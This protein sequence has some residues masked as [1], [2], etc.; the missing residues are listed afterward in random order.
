MICESPLEAN[1]QF[2][3]SDKEHA[4]KP[5]NAIPMAQRHHRAR[6]PRH[7]LGKGGHDNGQPDLL[8]YA[9]APSRRRKRACDLDRW[10]RNARRDRTPM[11]V[12][13]DLLWHS[14]LD[15]VVRL[16]PYLSRLD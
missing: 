13:P 8:Q 16:D 15:W 10:Q 6:V 4:H 11:A 14:S 7:A 2:A 12:Q 9:I 3:V 5:E 1:S